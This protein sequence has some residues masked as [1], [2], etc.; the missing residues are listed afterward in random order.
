MD[1]KL[2]ESFSEEGRERVRDHFSWD[3]ISETLASYYREITVR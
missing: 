1:R 2:C 3:G